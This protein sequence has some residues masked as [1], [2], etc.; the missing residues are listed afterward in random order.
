M[1]ICKDGRVWG[2]NNKKAGNH[3]GIILTGR[4][5][6]YIKKG[7]NLNSAFPKGKKHPNWN[8]GTSIHVKKGQIHRFGK[9]NPN[10][11]GGTSPLTMLVRS[12]FQ[13][14]QWR[15][16][17]FTRDDFTCQICGKRSEGD[18]E[19][20]HIKSFN[21]IWLENNIKTFEEALNCEELWNINNGRTLCQKCHRKTENYGNG[22]RGK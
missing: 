12:S 19:S 16:D 17:I 3:L 15:S 5:H 18:L 6:P 4:K 20:H 1:K 22:K 14:R 8:G 10:W 13:Y 21:S 11:K 2:Q 9:A 7:Y